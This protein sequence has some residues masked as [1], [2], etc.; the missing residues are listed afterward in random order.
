MADPLLFSSDSLASV[1]SGVPRGRKPEPDVRVWGGLCLLPPGM[2]PLTSENMHRLWLRYNVWLLLTFIA[3][4]GGIV[5]FLN[6]YS[7]GWLVKVHQMTINNT[8]FG[9]GIQF[10][11]W[12]LWTIGCIVLSCICVALS[13]SHA[14]EGTCPFGLTIPSHDWPPLSSFL[15][16][17]LHLWPY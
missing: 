8:K 3:M 5:A 13:D 9:H 6:E 2:R 11:L 14:A 7:S 10:L 17:L 4:G 16:F 15:G 1:G 12:T